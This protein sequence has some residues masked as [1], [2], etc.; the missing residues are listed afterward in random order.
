MTRKYDIGQ[1]RGAFNAGYEKGQSETAEEFIVI[2]GIV[3]PVGKWFHSF[4]EEEATQVVVWQGQVLKRVDTNSYRVQLYG[5]ILGDPTDVV[6]VHATQMMGWRFYD[7]DDEMRR[8]YYDAY[9]PGTNKFQW[10]RGGR[11]GRE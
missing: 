6:T 11:V 2:P 1:L 7:T 4:R 5:W 8:A 10:W 3:N 9:P